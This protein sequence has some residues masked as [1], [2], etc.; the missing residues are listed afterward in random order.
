MNIQIFTKGFYI[1][2]LYVLMN[3]FCG[4][5]FE[6]LDLRG[7]LGIWANLGIWSDRPTVTIAANNATEDF[8]KETTVEPLYSGHAL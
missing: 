6:A 3:L 7:L 1:H 4:V 2:S 8:I 5:A